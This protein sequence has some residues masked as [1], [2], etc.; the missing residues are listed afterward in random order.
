MYYQLVNSAQEIRK[1]IVANN[2]SDA[3][4]IGHELYPDVPLTITE[5]PHHIFH[6]TSA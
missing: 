3:I 5:I 1:D 2:A 6:E 4:V